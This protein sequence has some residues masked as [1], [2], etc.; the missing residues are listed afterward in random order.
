MGDDAGTLPDSPW[1]S[2]PA[3]NREAVATELKAEVAP[4]HPLQGADLSVAWRC[5]ACDD[6]LVGIGDD[7]FGIVHL[8]W[9]GQREIPPW[10]RFTPTGRLAATK[11]FLDAHAQLHGADLAA[12]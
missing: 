4:G 6:V 12:R 2:P 11:S 1:W 8:T 10:P 3:A 5:L 9:S 7:D